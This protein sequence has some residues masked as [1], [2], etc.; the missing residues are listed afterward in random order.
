MKHDSWADRVMY[1]AIVLCLA[2][3]AFLV[4]GCGAIG[5]GIADGLREGMS[6]NPSFPKS[7]PAGSNWL[8][9]IAYT[10]A[11]AAATIGAV[12]GRGAIRRRNGNGS[13]LGDDSRRG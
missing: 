2:I 12:W 8:E 4:V 5:A 3:L 6:E 11:G 13:P 7:P 10:A 9:T 1:V